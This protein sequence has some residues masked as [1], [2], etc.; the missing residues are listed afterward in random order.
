MCYV[1]ELLVV[2]VAA[3]AA[4][5][6]HQSVGQSVQVAV[7]KSNSVTGHVTGQVSHHQAH[8]NLHRRQAAESM[9]AQQQSQVLDRHNTLRAQEGAAHPSTFSTCW[10]HSMG[11]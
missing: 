10:A 5:T 2:L 11:P 3:A 4:V 7:I 1:T 8:R 6:M 9:S